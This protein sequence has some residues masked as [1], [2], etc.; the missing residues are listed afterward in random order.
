M[1]SFSPGAVA[2]IALWKSVP[3][4]YGVKMPRLVRA[5][6]RPVLIIGNERVPM[7]LAHCRF[8]GLA[9]SNDKCNVM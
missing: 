4:C 2:T 3:I 8:P 1:S 7:Q 5:I 9:I 6:F